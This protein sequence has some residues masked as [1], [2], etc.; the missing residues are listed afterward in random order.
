MAILKLTV[1]NVEISKDAKEAASKTLVLT[2]EQQKVGKNIVLVKKDVTLKNQSNKDQT[3]SLT[4]QNLQFTKK[5]YQ[6]TNIVAEIAV[7]IDDANVAWSPV[8]RDV[9]VS[10]FKNK[11]VSICDIQ[12]VADTNNIPAYKKVGEDFYVSSVQVK[13]KVDYMRIYLHINSLDKKMTEDITCRTF[14]GKK[15]KD[16]ILEEEFSKIKV[17]YDGDK[18]LAYDADS[19][20]NLSY[21]SGDKTTEHIFPFLVQ[22][23]ESFY[24]MLARTTN[25]WG[26]FMYY[27]DGKLIVGCPTS[28]AIKL[29]MTTA[30]VNAQPETL[31]VPLYE[32]ISYYNVDGQESCGGKYDCAAGY[33]GNMLKDPIRIDPEKISGNLFCW[34]GKLD[35]I[36]MKKFTNFFKND[37]NIPTFL[38]GELFDDL[39]DLGVQEISVSSKNGKRE[40]QFFTDAMKEKA[41]EQYAEHDYGKDGK[42][43]KAMSYNP[44]SEIHSIYDKKKYFG[45]LK[46]EILAGKDAIC[47]NFDTSYPCLKLGQVITVYDK[48]YIVTQIDCKSDH[49]LMLQDDLYV[50]TTEKV[51]YSFQ[52]Y[53]LPQINAG[54]EKEKK[55]QFFPTVI[56]S[57]HVRLADP[58]M[59]TVTD[60][61]DPNGAGRVRVM[62]DWQDVNKDKSDKITD[63]TVKA[64]SPWIQF[65]A[66]AGGGKGLMGA[67]YPGDKVFVNFIDGNVERPYVMGAISKGAGA[68][69]HCTT[70]GGHQLKIKDDAAGVMAFVTNMFTPVWGTVCDLVPGAGA[71]NPFSSLENNL[72]MAGG[73]EL[74]DNYGIYKI[75]GSTDGR[76][77]SIASP[78]GDVNIKAFSGISISAPNG[79][80]SIKGKNVS[81]EAGNN[82]TLTSGTNVGYKLWKDQGDKEAF[83]GATLG[84]S[85][86]ALVTKKLAEKF[87]KLVDL[88]MVRNVVEVVMRPV[89]GAMTLKSNRYMKLETGDK[90]CEYPKLAYNEARKMK[91]LN[92][93]VKENILSTVG[94]GITNISLGDGVV[95]LLKSG[96]SIAND[97]STKFV[98]KYQ[99][100]ISKK[101]ALITAINHLKKYSNDP[102]KAS[103]NTYEEMKDNLWKGDNLDEQ[104]KIE[105][106]GFKDD[107][108]KI[109]NVNTLNDL[110][111]LITEA[112]YTRLKSEY[113]G[114]PRK[115]Y[116]AI[117][118][119]RVKA[120][121]SAF[122][123]AKALRGAIVELLKIEMTKNDVDKHFSW[124]WTTMPKD[125]KKKALN[126]VS[127]EKCPN[128]PIYNP[129]AKVKK[130]DAAMSPDYGKKY[131]RRLIAMNLLEELGF[132]E[133][134]RGKI[135]IGNNPA[136]VPP[137]P[138]ASVINSN[139]AGSIL[140]QKT[141]MNYVRSLSGVPAI[142][143]D[144]TTL[145][146][147]VKGAVKKITS[148]MYDTAN[149]KKAYNEMYSW[150]D[151]SKGTILIGSSDNTFELVGNEFKQVT[152]VLKPSLKS[153]KAT[154]FTEDSDERKNIKEF[155]MKIKIALAKF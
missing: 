13:Y 107:N 90:S 88:S 121:A 103:C 6:P 126:A 37:K 94:N 48:D 148:E 70:P 74:S 139:T 108:C 122:K 16:G 76:E 137:K 29:P 93:E 33:D 71:L 41:P 59:A 34:G 111:Q 4:L 38:A 151:G 50:F 69:I 18:T 98:E 95:S 55:M 43:D 80:I 17:P 57:G 149:L 30:E 147:A 47:I 27:E 89:E 46:N 36:V 101:T 99:N 51:D 39:Y 28:T 26:E 5:M 131:M 19:M 124:Y 1:H 54:T 132:E 83:S 63:D 44:F 125:F 110:K 154:D 114:I 84:V 119:D 7:T 91:L 45:I 12:G 118:Q 62:F 31:K 130:L 42:V 25:R 112:C 106:M 15:L 32:S 24:D 153:L 58:Q 120:R 10:A 67:H 72:A 11:K 85:I 14:V 100:C 81:I 129:S 66:N 144:K 116:K 68:D 102:T 75:T 20:K 115:Q 87:V 140:H 136:A 142:S 104:F 138:D 133:D 53:A 2:T 23:N 9:A 73:F 145:G 86:A 128:S 77:V 92:A 127:K 117:L 152:E 64:S 56:P 79:D 22:Y 82:L 109:G 141:W 60:A 105:Q 135:I 65:A 78:W 35:K 40:D 134:M 61:G 3:Y 150:G 52:V 97:L 155:T 146:G 96:E 123:A 49:P 21:K 143:K 8:M 113:T